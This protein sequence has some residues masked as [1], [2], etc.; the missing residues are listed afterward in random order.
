MKTSKQFVSFLIAAAMLSFPMLL[1]SCKEQE[2]VGEWDNWQTRNEHYLD[3]IASVA[4]NS[5]SWTILKAFNLGDDF[6]M[7]KDN[8]YYV[9]V[10][11]LENGTGTYKPMYNDSIRVHYSGRLIPSASYPA[12]Y[13]FGKSYSTSTLNPE[14]D[15]PA[16][17]GVNQNVIGL[18]TAMMNMVE[19]DR[20]K[21]V[22]P[23]YIG[24]GSGDNSTV[25]IPA[26][27]PL[28]FDVKLAKIYKYGIDT[29]T[30][31]WT[32]RRK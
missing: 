29:D 1:S 3:S 20:W 19:G 6:G 21:I 25:S 17:M 5:S 24:Y 14:T 8:K 23:S 28:I 9:Y 12:G 32:K 30:S 22:I 31:W 11:K 2:D 13:N 4:K 18:A 16:L 7:D 27:S 15:V 26:G 10:Q